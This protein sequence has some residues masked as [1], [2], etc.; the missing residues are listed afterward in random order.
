MKKSN[1]INKKK[2]TTSIKWKFLG[3]SVTL[4]LIIISGSGIAFFLNMKRIVRNDTVQKLSRLIEFKASQLESST[5]K[6]I[7]IALK[8]ADSP[9]IREYF[10][11]PGNPELE[12]LAFKE[13]AGYRRAFTG[14]NVFWINDTDHN[15]YFGDEFI[16]TLDPAEPSSIW[17]TSIIKNPAPYFFDVDTNI[18]TKKTM[19]WINA[20]VMEQNRA[21]GVVGTGIDLTGF[22]DTLYADASEDMPFYLFN[23]DNVITGASD[24]DIVANK[25]TLTD[26]FGS[27]GE[28]IANVA[29]EVSEGLR[30]FSIG[31]NEYAVSYI[32]SL[33]WHIVVMMPLDAAIIF[34]SGMTYLFIMIFLVVL[35]IIAV[36]NIFIFRMIQPLD[37]AVK[38]LG[39]IAETWDL[40]RRFKVTSTDETGKLAEIL[41][42]TFGRIQELISIIHDRARSLVKTGSELS[43]QM[44]TTASSVAQIATATQNIRGQTDS[45]TGQ[46][47]QVDSSMTSIISLIEKLN[48]NITAQSESVNQSSS[49][50]EQMFANIGMVTNNLIKNSENVNA[51]EESSSVNRR[52][53]E[54]VSTEFKDITR[55]SEGLL[56]INAVINNIASQTNLL[57]MN[58]AIEA[59]HAGESGRGFA[60]VAGEIRKLAEDSS[61]QSKTIADMVKKMKSAIDTITRSINRVINRFE[62]VDGKVKT[63][64]EQ[65]TEIRNA[66][67]E[68]ETGSRQILEAI[69]HLKE[70]TGIVQTDAATIVTEGKTVIDQSNNLKGITAGIER[71]M[72][73]MS[74][75][76]EHIKAAVNRVNEISGENKNSTDTLIGEVSKFKIG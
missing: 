39:E 37:A 54:S 4:L 34:N 9:I 47:E 53:L 19:L 67:E 30:S 7:A 76:A 6:E 52:D 75:G 1:V 49:A 8:M 12:R 58:A 48:G 27:L 65:E 14:N 74:V 41:N 15:Y 3:F 10:L 44:A 32:P 26:Q 20:P 36:I 72:Q 38:Q 18:E 64:A 71:G 13:I 70:L 55:Q 45:Q 63:I 5:S 57:S 60:V 31:N 22:I 16:H 11:Q 42:L 17:Y 28:A 66:M 33:N 50:I 73:E 43:E 25:Q 35:I 23:T 56:E 61:K 2:P 40:T 68:Q 24:W 62:D 21:I 59:A 29:K 46:V 51:L 69:T